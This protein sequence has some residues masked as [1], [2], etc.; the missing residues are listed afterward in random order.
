MEKYID[1]EKC[2]EFLLSLDL[3]DCKDKNKYIKKLYS[4]SNKVEKNYKVFKIKKHNGKYRTICAP[5]ATLKHIQRQILNN[6][7]V[8]QKISK[9]AKAYQKNI[10]LKENAIPHLNKKI[11]LKL[12]IKNFFDNISFYDVY[13]NCF[14]Y[15]PKSV[16]MLLTYLCTYY[17]YIPQGA[18][19]SAY[20]SNVIMRD[21]DEK[22][23]SFCEK[24]NISYTRYSDDMTFSG[25]FNTHELIRKVRELLKYKGLELNDKK[26]HIFKNY[27]RQEV[28]G[29]V[30][31]EKLQVNNKYRKNIRQSMYYINKFGLESHLKS[32]GITN[33]KEYLNQLYGK[34]LFVLQINSN[35]K[36]F[37]KYKN[38]LG[39]IEKEIF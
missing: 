18:P 37:Q 12:D 11:I 32:L 17:D 8:D 4:I 9:Y 7:L 35:D 38:I 29:I 27:Q 15:F 6:I 2:N 19:T 22:I 34:V 36:E 3:F 16:G 21:F 28:T 33:K 31:N 30:V 13:N 25:D 24:R 5:N 10:P 23:G 14:Y 1:K 39:K 20:I 26:L